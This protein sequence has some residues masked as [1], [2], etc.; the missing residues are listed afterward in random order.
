[1]DMMLNVGQVELQFWGLFNNLVFKYRTESNILIIIF[2]F[3]TIYHQPAWSHS[4]I[5][6]SCILISPEQNRE[7]Q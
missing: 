7:K 1:M 5:S 3:Y 6:I 2:S 4:S